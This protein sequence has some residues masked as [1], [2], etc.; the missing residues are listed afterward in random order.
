MEAL[1]THFWLFGLPPAAS[2]IMGLL[3]SKFILSMI[4]IKAFNLTD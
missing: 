2:Q 1:A 3:A 4:C